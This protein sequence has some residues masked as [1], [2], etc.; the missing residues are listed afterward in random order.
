DRADIG[1]RNAD[2]LG[3][4]PRIAAGHV[5]IAEEAGGRIAPELLG[6]PRIW[7]RVLAERKH[8]LAAMQ[9]VAAGDG[10]R[11]DDAVADGEVLHGAADF[12]DLPHEL[13][14]ENV[15]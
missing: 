1:E 3:L 9:T 6:H 2:V 14:A 15:A 10:E 11:I 8:L 12:D 5:G 13:M 7:I 4:A